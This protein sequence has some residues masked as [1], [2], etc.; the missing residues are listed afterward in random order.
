MGTFRYSPRS[1]ATH[2]TT[3]R[4]PKNTLVEKNTVALGNFIMSK[5]GNKKRSFT[6]SEIKHT[7]ALTHVTHTPSPQ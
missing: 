1:R 7:H 4:E 6:D 2:I 3:I 5:I